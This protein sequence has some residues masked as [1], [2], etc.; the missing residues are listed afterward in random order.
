[1]E[2]RL[3]AV[4]VVPYLQQ[5]LVLFFDEHLQPLLCYIYDIFDAIDFLH[6]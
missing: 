6:L 3:P 5:K 4:E 1:M 2:F